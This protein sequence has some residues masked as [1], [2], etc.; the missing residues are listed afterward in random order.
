MK[1]TI[2]NRAKNRGREVK[3]IGFKIINRL[4]SARPDETNA[5]ISIASEAGEAMANYI[6]YGLNEKA[7]VKA[8]VKSLI[9]NR[10]LNMSIDTSGVQD[11]I[12]QGQ[13]ICNDLTLTVVARENVAAQN[14]L[15]CSL[16]RLL[17]R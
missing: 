16:K 1:T 2:A 17:F 3:A 15:L 10:T 4:T 14:V 11:G 7:R 13:P 6:E 12:R 8:T 9:Q 5:Y